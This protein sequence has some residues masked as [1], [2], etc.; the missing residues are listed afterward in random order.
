MHFFANFKLRSKLLLMVLI[1]LVGLLY[2]SLN[3]TVD[4][5]QIAQ[6]IAALDKLVGV[7]VKIGAVAHELQK[8]RGMSAGFIGSQGTKFVSELPTQRAESDARLTE[9]N[10][11]LQNFDASAYGATLVNALSEAQSLLSELAGKRQ[12][13]SALSIPGPEAIGF[14][15]RTIGKL[16]AVSGSVTTLSHNAEIAQLA[17]A[18]A[19]FLQGKERAGIERATLSN[20]FAADHFT[21]E[22]MVRYLSNAAAQDTFLTVFQSYASEQ[23]I[24]FYKQKVQGSDVEEVARYKKLAQEQMQA[25]SLGQDATQW[26]RAATV[27][28]DLLKEVEDHLADSLMQKAAELRSEGQQLMWFY[29]GL[30]ILTIGL[31]LLLTLTIIHQIMAQMGG[32]PEAAV[33]L[34]HN[35][36]DGRLD[37]AI[38]LKS[39]DRDSLFATMKRMQEQ[40]LARITESSRIADEGLLIKIALDNVS[41]GVMM[42]DTGRRIIYANKAVLQMFKH[43]EQDIRKQL[44]NFN[45]DNLMGANI[46]QFHKN[47]SHQANMLAS[48]TSTYR[49][50]LN[51][52]VRSMTVVANPVINEKNERLGSVV[53]WKDRT[54]EVVVERE[55]ADLVAAAAAGDFSHRLNPAGK[56]GFFLQLAD[57]INKLVETSERGMTDVARVLKALSEGDLTHRIDGDYEGL[58]GQLQNDTNATSERLSEIVAQIRE[59]TDAINTASRE[60]ASGNTDLSSRTE[61]QAASLEETASSIDQFT[62][63]VKQNADNARQANQLAKGASEIAIKGGEVVGQVVHTMGAIAESSRKIADIISVIDGIAFQTNILALNAAVEAA[64]AGEQ[65]RGFAVVAGE[66]RSLAQRSAAAAKEIKGLIGDSTDKVTDGY[67]LVEQAGGTMGE[68]VDA[69]KRVT[70]IM[71]EIS[72]ASTEQSQ[73]IQQVNQAIMQMDETTQQNAALVEEAA[74]AAES[75]QDQAASL[76][77]SVSVFRLESGRAHPKLISSLAASTP[78]ARPALPAPARTQRK[79]VQPRVRNES[80]DEWEEF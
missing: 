71:G 14:Y 27:R 65:G 19:A 6:D 53:E 78:R 11:T 26:F 36:A 5:A 8:E 15:S 41:S 50:A 48:F 46:D 67:R 43:A 63:T 76:S 37:N 56:E 58:F 35:I 31:T 68:V 2:F 33:M 51:I 42:A 17:S 70:D 62:S 34:A 22:M 32:E 29:L 40:L 28:I 18:Y 73:G 80:A 55:V 61:S 54:E 4:K 75:L 30:S 49:S 24:D 9:L 74:A 64:R 39:G 7:S 13:I 66:V 52:G 57:G 47:P 21:P 72:A 77:Q 3:A 38:V 10:T 60:I 44:P 23:Q 20:V 25:P 59:A 79:V 1:P 45:A 12:S 16:L 69:V